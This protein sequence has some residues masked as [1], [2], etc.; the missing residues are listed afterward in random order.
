MNGQRVARFR[1]LDKERTGELVSALDERESIAGF[2][3]RVAKAIQRIRVENVSGLQMCDGR[4]D[5]KNVLHIVNR[6]VKV[7]DFG[8][9]NRRGSLRQSC[10]RQNQTESQEIDSHEVPPCIKKRSATNS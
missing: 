8:L 7:H 6:R 3:Q 2:L 9:R 10:K 1:S 5:A 4:R